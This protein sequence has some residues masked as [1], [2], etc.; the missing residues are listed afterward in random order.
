MELVRQ[1]G[2]FL[3]V[4]VEIEAVDAF[5]LLAGLLNEGKG[6]LIAANLTRTPAREELFNFGPDYQQT[7][8]LVVYRRG[9]S[10][11]RSFGDLVGRKVMVIAD[12]SY[13]EALDLAQ[14]DHPELTWEPRSDIGMEEL[15]LAVSDRAIDITLVDSV[16]FGL[17]GH[18]YPRVAAAFTLPGTLPLAWAF[19]RGPDDSLLRKAR[20]FMLQAEQDSRLES[21]LQLCRVLIRGGRSEEAAPLLAQLRME[22]PQGVEPVSLSC[23]AAE[24]AG[25][26]ETA[27]ALLASDAAQLQAA[28]SQKVRSAHRLQRSTAD[29]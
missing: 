26:W 25:D 1:F 16:N 17:N 14:F 10:R 9:Q 15:L 19:P 13:E 12:S 23:W 11:P 22:F 29:R 28:G 3:G 24:E 18:Y 27:G 21:K 7:S 2:D 8:M 20:T 5:S 6:D 4:G